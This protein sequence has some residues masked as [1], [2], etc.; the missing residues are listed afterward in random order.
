MGKKA[1][2]N[3]EQ[4]VQAAEKFN[5]QEYMGI[6]G[7]ANEAPT[8]AADIGN[9]KAKMTTNQPLFR[10]NNGSGLVIFEHAIVEVDEGSFARMLRYH[11]GKTG[12]HL[13][14]WRDRCFVIGEQ[15]YSADPH[16]EPRQGRLKY[17]RD[18]YGLLFIRGLVELFNG[19]IPAEINAFLAHPPGDLEHTEALKKSVHGRWI[20]EVNGQRHQTTV[21]Y[22]N[23]FDEIVGGVHNATHGVDGEPIKGNALEGNGPCIVYDLGGGSLDLAYLKPDL[24]VDY[25]RGMVSHRIGINTAVENFKSAFDSRYAKLL[26]DAENGI[27]RQVVIDIFMD[28]NHIVSDAGADL[29]C[30]DLYQEAIAPIIRQSIQ[31]VRDFAG[32]SIGIRSVLL[33]GGG[34]AMC[35]DEIME[36][37]FPRFAGNKK[38][39]TTDQ[40]RDMVGANV[41]GGLKIAKAMSVSSKIQADFWLRTQGYGQQTKR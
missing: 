4:I 14:K 40:P 15:A 12:Y 39:F 10:G 21:I 19:Q 36:D 18:Y 17:S 26:A 7:F 31:A 2:P 8:V 24:S 9:N 29:D 1:K 28:E 30:S 22:T 13:I 5:E 41:R 37:V 35:M 38:V 33:T 6:L 27:S 11:K 34:S 16:F 25:D 32:G 20:F 3:D 23:S